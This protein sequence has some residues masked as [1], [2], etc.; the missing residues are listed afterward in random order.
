MS[1][2]RFIHCADLH[3]G[4]RFSGLSSDDADLGR[5]L[6]ESVFESFD[7][8]ADLAVSEDADFVVIAG[9]VFDEGN[10]SPRTRNRFCDTV[11]RMGVPCFIAY[12]NHD[13]NRRWDESIP[14]P[15]NATVVP[16]EGCSFVFEKDGAAVA[17]VSGAS[18]GKRHESRDLTES[19]AGEPGL[20]SVGVVHCSVDAPAGE[21]DYS[22]C[23]LSEMKARGIDYW[24]LGHIHLRAVLSEH[25]YA[26]YPG[27]IQ[28]RSP[29]ETGEKGAYVVTVRDGRVSDLTFKAT[30]SIRWESADADITGKSL[31]GLISDISAKV[32]K[33]SLVRLS[34]KGRGDLDRMVRLDPDGF[35]EAVRS[36]TGCTVTGI[37]ARTGPD[38]D[39]EAR[40]RSG[41]FTASV[42]NAADALSQADRDE[43]VDRICSTKTSQLFAEHFRS[44]SDEELRAIVNDA[45]M[46]MVEKLAEAER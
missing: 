14:L 42:L 34:L 33:G 43:I 24:A 39:L 45:G 36:K 44:M 2:F 15:D 13:H 18:F 12:G 21:T 35:S 9:D 1:Q 28:G 29:K 46:L 17:S 8:I 32:P 3:L 40:R 10:E 11:R 38:M 26:V 7:R 6:Q 22:P 37:E 16:A 20:F 31:D 25:P 19:V 30:Q 4:C 23:K 27:N 5:K 41:D